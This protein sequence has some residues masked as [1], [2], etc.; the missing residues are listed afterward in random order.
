M[1]SMARINRCNSLRVSSSWAGVLLVSN[2]S[3]CSTF[4]S[5]RSILHEA[6]WQFWRIRPAKYRISLMR[7]ASVA[8]RNGANSSAFGVSVSGFSFH[9]IDSSLAVRVRDIPFGRMRNHPT[10]TRSKTPAM[11]SACVFVCLIRPVI[12][13]E[14]PNPVQA[15]L[16]GIVPFAGVGNRTVV[17]GLKTPTVLAISVGVDH[18]RRH[19]TTSRQ[20]FLSIAF[21]YLQLYP[22]AHMFATPHPRVK[23]IN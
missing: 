3:P 19:C 8:I 18:E 11:L 2:D 12:L 5:S 13:L 21:P 15:R 16:L 4:E 10:V 22:P 6:S 9:R 14:N 1:P 17:V 23:G 7:S 20:L